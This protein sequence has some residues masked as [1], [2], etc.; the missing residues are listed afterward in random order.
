[1]DQTLK[2]RWI[3][4]LRSGKY[5]QT[6]GD[7]HNL[8][9]YCCLGVLCDIQNPSQTRWCGGDHVPP[10]GL[11]AGLTDDD[12]EVLVEANDTARWSFD[13]IATYIEVML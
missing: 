10:K 4:A 8:G 6:T 11:R 12:F 3:K 1:M 2:R 7:L 13:D 9:A 5:Q